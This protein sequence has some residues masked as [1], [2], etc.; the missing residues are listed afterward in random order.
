MNYEQV[1]EELRKNPAKD[2]AKQHFKGFGYMP[3]EVVRAKLHS[4]FGVYDWDAKGE[5]SL[6]GKSYTVTGVLTVQVGDRKVSVTGFGNDGLKYNK[7]KKAWLGDPHQYIPSAN[8]YALKNACI[9]LGNTFGAFIEKEI[10]LSGKTEEEHIEH[11]EGLELDALGAY[12]YTMQ[13]HEKTNNVKQAY[14]AIKIKLT[15]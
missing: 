5:Q 10:T 12:W 3:I 7:T 1:L 11:M 9:A 8:S 14:K 13:P 15:K 2:E 4:I 6:D